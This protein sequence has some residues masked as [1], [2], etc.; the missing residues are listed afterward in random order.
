MLSPG[1][2]IAMPQ[3]GDSN[4]YRSVILMLVHS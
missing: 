4:F 3:L 1:F 2:L